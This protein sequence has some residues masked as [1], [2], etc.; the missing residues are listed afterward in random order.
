MSDEFTI[1]PSVH[2]CDS[3]ATGELDDA[4]GIGIRTDL[5]F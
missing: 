5:S 3:G 4:L 1:Q 2:G